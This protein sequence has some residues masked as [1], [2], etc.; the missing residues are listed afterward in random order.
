KNCIGNGKEPSCAALADH[1]VVH[2]RMLS[3]KPC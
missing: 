2:N 3:I 1:Q